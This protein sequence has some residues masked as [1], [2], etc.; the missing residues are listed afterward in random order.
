LGWSQRHDLQ[1]DLILQGLRAA[2][3]KM[4]GPR[5]YDHERAAYFMKRLLERSTRSLD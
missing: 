5:N 3:V 1:A 4:R 2:G